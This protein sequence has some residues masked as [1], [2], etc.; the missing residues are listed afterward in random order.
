[1]VAHRAMDVPE[2][3]R[4]EIFGPN[5][6]GRGAFMSA[7]ALRKPFL[8]PAVKFASRRAMEHLCPRRGEAAVQVAVEATAPV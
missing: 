1:M 6:T 4:A 2:K 8:P 7:C 3:Q 5:K